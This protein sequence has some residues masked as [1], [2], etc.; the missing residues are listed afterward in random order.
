MKKDKVNKRKMNTYLKYGLIM[1]GRNDLRRF[2]WWRDEL[3][4]SWC[5]IGTNHPGC[6]TD[7]GF[8]NP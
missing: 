2:S 1:L 3:S 8:G 5:A 6:S 4:E 7:A